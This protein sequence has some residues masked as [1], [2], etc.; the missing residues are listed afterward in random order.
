LIEQTIEIRLKGRY[1]KDSYGNLLYCQ[2]FFSNLNWVIYSVEFREWS[3]IF[4]SATHKKKAKI[5]PTGGLCRSSADGSVTITNPACI[6]WLLRF[7]KAQVHRINHKFSGRLNVQFPDNTFPMGLNSVRTEVKMISNLLR[8]TS[9][10]NQF[11]YFCFP[12]R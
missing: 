9:A 5:F 8:R 4:Q 3:V 6:Q 11:Q 1:L 7:Y 10:G 2:R 12:Y